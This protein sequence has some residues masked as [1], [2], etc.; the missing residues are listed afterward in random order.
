MGNMIGKDRYNGHQ[1][2]GR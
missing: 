2:R 1:E